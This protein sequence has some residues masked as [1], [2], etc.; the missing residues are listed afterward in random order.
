MSCRAVR[1]IQKA[2]NIHPSTKLL[3][4]IFRANERLAAQQSILLHKRAR[5]VGALQIEKTKRKR[6]KRLNLLGEEDSGPQF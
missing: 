6:G 1:R 5:L 2:Y 3:S 4:L